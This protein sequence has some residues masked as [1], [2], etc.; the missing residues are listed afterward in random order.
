MGEK[1]MKNMG[2]TVAGK[3]YVT[4]K[5]EENERGTQQNLT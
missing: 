4:A 2:K 1:K 3:R 5:V